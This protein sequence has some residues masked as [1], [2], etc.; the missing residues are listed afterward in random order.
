[1]LYLQYTIKIMKQIISR[2]R[3]NLITIAVMVATFVEILN[4]S[5]ANVALKYMAGSFSISNDESLWIV[6]MFLISC[7]V[8]LP[9]TDWFCSVMGRK[10]FFLL[11]IAVFGIA[12][13][14]CGISTSFSMM[15][16]GRIMQGLGG[17]CLI[18]LSQAILLESYPKEEHRKAMSIFALGVTLAPVVGPILGG[19]LTTNLSWNFVFFVSIPFC[20][21]A[22]TMVSLVIKDPPYMKAIGLHKMDYLG[23][24]LLV[25]WVS[26]FQIMLDN[27]QKNG[28]FDSNYIRNLGICALVSFI[29][30]IWWELKCEKPLLDLT[31][32]Q[33]RNF[34]LGTLLLTSTYGVTYCTIVMLPQF[35][36]TLMGYDS[37]LSGIAAT[38]MGLGTIVG[39]V[40]TTIL[41]KKTDLKKISFIGGFVFAFGTYLFSCLNLSIALINVVIPNI[42][43]GIGITML[44]VPLTTLT[45][46]YVSNSEMTNAS[47]IQNLIKNVGCAI[48]TSSVGVLVSRYS[49]VYQTYLVGNLT[50]TNS[51]YSQKLATLTTFFV[52]QGA[53]YMTAQGKAM[54]M[55]YKQLLQQSTLCAFMNAYKI[56]ALVILLSIPLIIMLK[57]ENKVENKE[58][59]K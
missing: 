51:V 26:T 28:W 29:A 3:L 4:T 27:G 53:D 50:P 8:L 42:V 56:Y 39:V 36:Q 35:L 37:F 18:P 54:V 17:G 40:I 1:M 16:F 21:V 23:L 10:K 2:K 25:I 5:I 41:A 44:T 49:Q 38:P 55:A 24:A 14:I 48:G 22:F 20:I 33:N 15:I 32:F 9:V 58:D 30:L 52:Q 11:C 12:S 43:L 46:T 19:W 13:F 31:I 6:T 47:S 57:K 45:F 7:S 59:K 34:T